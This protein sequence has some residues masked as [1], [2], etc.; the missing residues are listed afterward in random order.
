MN[1]VPVSGSFTNMFD[2]WFFDLPY[3]FWYV[4]LIMLLFSLVSYKARQLTLSGAA[5]AFF[6]GFGITTNR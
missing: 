2:L 6:I 4:A 1:L 5:V 3:S